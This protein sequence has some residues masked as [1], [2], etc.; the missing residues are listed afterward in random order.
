MLISVITIAVN[1]LLFLGLF[2]YYTRNERKRKTVEA[3][4]YETSRTQVRKIFDKQNESLAK[5][6]NMEA[7]QKEIQNLKE[8]IENLFSSLSNQLK[9]LPIQD[10]LESIEEVKYI[11][12]PEPIPKKNEIL[13]FPAPIE[14]FKF[15][16]L[17]SSFEKNYFH[18][19]AFNLENETTA[20]FDFIQEKDALQRAVE[21]SKIYIDF[22]SKSK[23]IK[24]SN[25]DKFVTHKKGRAVK[26][27]DFWIIKEEI[28]GEYIY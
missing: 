12:K 15:R 11:D 27:G 20:T 7:C 26:E 14:K 10:K 1:I 22:T 5:I 16:V 18:V 24:K 9:T 2:I 8:A 4:F 13:Y 6:Q 28:I 3:E 23:N 17:D 19:F 25:K 21:S